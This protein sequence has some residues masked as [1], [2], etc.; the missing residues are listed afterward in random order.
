MLYV[1]VCEVYSYSQNYFRTFQGQ[2]RRSHRRRRTALIKNLELPIPVSS[3]AKVVLV[4]TRI[5]ARDGLDL[6]LEGTEPLLR[7]VLWLLRYNSASGFVKALFVV[8][9]CDD[10][11]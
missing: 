7:G 1:R 2:P 9:L 5:R 10:V 11:D 3:R 8:V 6:Y 4:S